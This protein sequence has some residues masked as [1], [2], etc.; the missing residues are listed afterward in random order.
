VVT[1]SLGTMVEPGAVAVAQA[2]AAAGAAAGLRL[3]ERRRCRW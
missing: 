2:I 3:A 1:L